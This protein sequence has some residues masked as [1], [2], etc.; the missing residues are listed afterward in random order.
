MLSRLYDSLLSLSYPQECKV[1]GQSVEKSAIGVACASCWDR[2]R[3]FSDRETLCFKCGE[4]LKD[5]PTSFPTFCRLCGDHSYDRAFSVGV[6]EFAL[7]VSVLNLKSEPVVSKR[8]AEIFVFR[9]QSFDFPV[10]DLIVPVPLSAKRRLERGFNQAEVL[11]GIL[12]KSTGIEVDNG[13]LVRQVHTPMH[14]AGMD[15]KARELTV[16]KAFA[17]KRPKLISGKK[18]L[19]IDDIFT[20]GSTA[21]SCAGALK[22][23]GADTVHVMTVARAV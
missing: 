10:P 2:T 13:S 17:V 23:S 7:A 15:R 6:Y 18:I 22:K 12:C 4:F 14:R 3:I 9:F 21:S 11:S 16:K 5:S 20:S 19:L 1:C 8:L